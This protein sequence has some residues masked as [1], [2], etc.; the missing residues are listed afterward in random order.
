MVRQHLLSGNNIVRQ[1][2]SGVRPAY[3]MKKRGPPVGGPLPFRYTLMV[4]CLSG[5]EPETSCSTDKRSNRLSYRHHAMRHERRGVSR[6]LFEMVISLNPEGWSRRRLRD[7]SRLPASASNLQAAESEI[8]AG[9]IALF[10]PHPKMWPWS[11]LLSHAEACANLDCRCEKSHLP[12]FHQAP[13][14]C[15]ARTFL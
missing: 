15:A 6:V 4:G 13:L 2:V 11:L 5:L 9:R 3:S 12:G 10:T 1:P 14:L 7:G 8:A